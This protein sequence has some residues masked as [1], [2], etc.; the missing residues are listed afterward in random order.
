MKHLNIDLINI[1]LIAL[2]LTIALIFPFELFLYSYAILGPLHYIT[3]LNWLKGKNYFVNIRKS[4]MIPFLMAAIAVSIY[5]VVLHLWPN[6]STSLKFYL[7]Q[8]ADGSNFLMIA[9]FFF[10][11]AL[12]SLKNQ[13]Q[14]LA[15][16]AS[17]A[18]AI[19]IYF[20]LPTSFI[21]LAVFLPTLLHVYVFTALFILY[22]ARKSNSLLGL[23]TFFIM[24][25]VPFI[26]YLLPDKLFLNAPSETTLSTYLNS[27]MI[28]VNA[29]LAQLINGL[30]SGDFYATS[31]SGLKIQT[32]IGFAYTYHYL[33]WFSKTSIIGW[34]KELSP[35]EIMAIGLFWFAA[36]AIY[37]YD[38]QTG[39]IILFLLSF[40]HV[41]L[42]F[43]LNAITI[44]ALLTFKK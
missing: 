9:V 18:I 1:V 23:I 26:I 39:F 8:L 19:L 10:S 25:I 29:F 43:P 11:I 38:F 44:K 28:T 31:I 30:E 37:F 3:E 16:G 34:Y 4:W 20:I 32:F 21:Y 24:I 5:P 36:I 33:N 12:V 42:E 22:G 13:K 17:L 7:N 41:V 14:L 2:S 15:F 6:P 27:N 40:I 35:K